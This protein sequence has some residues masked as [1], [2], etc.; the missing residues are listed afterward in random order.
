MCGSCATEYLRYL[1]MTQ[2]S[3]ES[4]PKSSLDKSAPVNYNGHQFI[5]K[6][7]V[8][9]GNLLYKCTE[10]SCLSRIMVSKGDLSVLKM[11]SQHSGHRSSPA[12]VTNDKDKGTTPL[13]ATTNSNKTRA[14][15]QSIQKALSTP[16][17][18]SPS[19]QLN[20]QTKQ[21]RAKVVKF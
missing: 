17:K 15:T 16:N 1:T 2:D 21:Q 19:V 11:L 4:T 18:T 20:N 7:S 9:D 3:T 14:M 13:S 8:K 12:A 5:F 6:Y 10:R